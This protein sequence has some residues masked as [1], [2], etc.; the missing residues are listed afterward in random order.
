MLTSFAQVRSKLQKRCAHYGKVGHLA[1]DCFELSQAERG[2]YRRWQS[3]RG[4]DESS[5]GTSGSSKSGASHVSV[6]SGSNQEMRGDVVG[7][8]HCPGRPDKV[9]L[10]FQLCF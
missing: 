10:D 5:V 2:E 7:K 4:D 1:W 8:L 9:Y 3:T 6:D